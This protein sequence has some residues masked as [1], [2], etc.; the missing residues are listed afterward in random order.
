M[1]FVNGEIDKNR[2][3][4]EPGHQIIDIENNNP[5]S[6]EDLV[7]GTALEKR[8]GQKPYEVTD[9]KIWDELAHQLSYGLY[10]T[11]LHWSPD[12]VVLGGPMMVGEPSM[13]YRGC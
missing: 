6:L 12:A 5:K 1:R 11:I 10:N 8:T 9:P 4:F 3:G 7:S 2:F 13:E